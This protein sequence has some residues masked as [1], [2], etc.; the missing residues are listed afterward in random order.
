MKWGA[1]CLF[2]LVTIAILISV[3]VVPH[4]D[5]AHTLLY[6]VMSLAL[7]AFASAGM[8][9]SSL[10]MM[11]SPWYE[12]YLAQSASR[13]NREVK[14]AFLPLVSVIIPAWNEEVGLVNTV[15]TVLASTYRNLEIVVVNDGSTDQSDHIMH[16]F[17]RKYTSTMAGINA[18]PVLY[19]YQP[20]GGK[21]AALNTGIQMAHGD[22]LITIDADCVLQRDAISQFVAPF[23]D[24]TVMCVAG[25]I[26][27][28]NTKTLLGSIQALEYTL[29]FYGRKADAIMGTIYIVGGAA[30]AFRRTVFEK[31][32]PYHTHHVT[33]DMDLSFRIQQAGLQIAYAP[34]AIVYTECADTLKS[35]A[36]QRLRW[37][38]GRFE[39]FRAHPHF[40]FSREHQ[41]NKLLTWLLLPLSMLEDYLFVFKTLLKAALYV[42]CFIAHDFSIL[43]LA[44]TLSSVVAFIPLYED[45]E[46]RNR[47]FLTPIVWALIQLPA[48]VEFYALI[49]AVWGLWRKKDLKW[50]RWQRQGAI[51]QR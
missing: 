36:K 34:G 14:V 43:G 18:P 20:N 21:G 9:K 31:I 10:Y 3:F 25:H 8:M 40:A 24:P 5:V 4:H 12:L 27:I 48:A 2:Y 33:E 46:R 19:Y 29:G 35:M 32:G 37:K 39:T 44:I 16:Q 28:G 15:K 30:G 51:D 6:L 26:K 17:L 45:K 11:L 49:V 42:Y 23:T 13:R 50:Q 7:S 47:A 22:I 1:Y 38:R 41:H